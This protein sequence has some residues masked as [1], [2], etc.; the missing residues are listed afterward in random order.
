MP[1]E[2]PII[3]E[4]TST[5]QEWGVLWKQLYVVSCSST[6][7]VGTNARNTTRILCGFCLRPPQGW[8]DVKRVFLLT[9]SASKSGQYLEIQPKCTG[10]APFDVSPQHVVLTVI[11][12]SHVASLDEQRWW[13]HSVLPRAVSRRVIRAIDRSLPA[14][15]SYLVFYSSSGG[16][17]GGARRLLR[18]GAVRIR[19]RAGCWLLHN[20]SLKSSVNKRGTRGIG[21]VM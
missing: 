20:L 13:T 21:V 12:N 5:L 15:S 4:T 19:C 3:T 16:G 14:P 7:A 6:P 1:L 17:G 18:R 9:C 11:L 10:T 2:D 8:G